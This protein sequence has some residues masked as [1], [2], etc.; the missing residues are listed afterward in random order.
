LNLLI[1]VIKKLDPYL[2]WP[3]LSLIGVF[4]KK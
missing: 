2:P 1:P 4:E 3:S